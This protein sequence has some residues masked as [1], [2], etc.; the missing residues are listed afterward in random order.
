MF[1]VT[2]IV[3][4][5]TWLWHTELSSPQELKLLK[6]SPDIKPHRVRAPIL[7][8]FGKMNEPDTLRLIQTV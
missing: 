1:K 7:V 8:S 5:A 4:D 6:R 2:A 3:G